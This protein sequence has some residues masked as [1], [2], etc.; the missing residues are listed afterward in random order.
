[1]ISAIRFATDTKA[2]P[3]LTCVVLSNQD[4]LYCT[5]MDKAISVTMDYGKADITPESIASMTFSKDQREQAELKYFDG[6]D[7]I[8]RLEPSELTFQIVP[9]TV[10]KVYADSISRLARNVAMPP[11]DVSA[12]IEKLIARLGAESYKDRQAAMDALVKKGK[13]IIPVL[14]KFA[15]SSDAEVRQRIEEVRDKLLG[16]SS[17]PAGPM[18]MIDEDP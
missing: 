9:G 8:G 2:D 5:M 1:M 10:L 18:P 13:T 16:K 14:E 6:S 12:D 11:G 3:M 7:F 17:S 15:N 4:E